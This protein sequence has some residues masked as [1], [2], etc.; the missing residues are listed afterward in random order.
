M[1][2]HIVADVR[3]PVQEILFLHHVEDRSQQDHLAGVTHPSVEHAIRL[4]R[5]VVV[6]DVHLI[7]RARFRSS[8]RR[9]LTRRKCLLEGLHV[10]IAAQL[11]L[12][13]KGHQIG[14]TVQIEVLVAPHL[15]RWATTGLHFVDEQRCSVLKRRRQAFRHRDILIPTN[16]R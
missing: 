7:S 8:L 9:K 14:R 13:A 4:L 5:P 11:H 15:S 6:H 16:F 12:L 3:Y 10:I 2:H 1:F